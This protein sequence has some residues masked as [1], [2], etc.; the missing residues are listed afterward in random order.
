MIK[1]TTSN[2][3]KFPIFNPFG[4]KTKYEDMF[5]SI[6]KFEKEPDEEIFEIHC[7]SSNIGF[8]LSFFTNGIIYSWYDYVQENGKK[9]N[10]IM[11]HKQKLYLSKWFN[12]IDKRTGK[13]HLQVLF[14]KW[15]EVNDSD[16]NLDYKKAIRNM[17]YSEDT[18][19]AIDLTDYNELK[20]VRLKRLKE[21]VNDILP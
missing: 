18:F 9:E 13:T 3:I 6:S 17:L 19:N 2:P 15:Y 20:F 8:Y 1:Y 12:K 21:K 5:F 4:I 14:D 11:N 7:Y 16:Y 10:Y